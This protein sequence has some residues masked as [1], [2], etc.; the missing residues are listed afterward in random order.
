MV[1]F[2][3]VQGNGTSYCSEMGRTDGRKS[4]K[5]LQKA[6]K[7]VAYLVTQ[8]VAYLPV[9]ER[10]QADIKKA[11]EEEALLALANRLVS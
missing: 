3:H 1:G 9:F 7:R 2:V 8:D 5:E 11:Q 6:Q 10:I 4:L